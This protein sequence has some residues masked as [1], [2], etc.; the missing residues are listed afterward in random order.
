[1]KSEIY[2]KAELKSMKAQLPTIA[3]NKIFLLIQFSSGKSL[4]GLVPVRSRSIYAVVRVNIDLKNM[5][6]TNGTPPSAMY[7]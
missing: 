2:G 1:M 4:K 7:L 6:T 3:L 5:K